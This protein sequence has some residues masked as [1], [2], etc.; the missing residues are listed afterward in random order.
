MARQS[1]RH[2]RLKFL[3]T[4]RFATR[5]KQQRSAPRF[6]TANSGPVTLK[7]LRAGGATLGKVS[8]VELLGSDVL[9]GF[10][11]DDQGLTVT[12]RGSGSAATS[13]H[14]AAIGLEM[15]CSA[16]SA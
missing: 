14:R 8:K 15:S 7:A 1:L 16:H 4:I 12:P 6:W 9:L 10:V 5:A 13:D 2:A 3:V 11:Q